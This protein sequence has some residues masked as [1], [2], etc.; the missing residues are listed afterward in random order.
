MITARKIRV[1]TALLV[2]MLAA[3]DAA[4]AACTHSTTIHNDSSIVLRFAELRSSYSPPFFDSQ[5]TGSRVIQPGASAT[6]SWTSDLN[7]TDASGVNNHWDV[8]FIRNIGRV[9]YCA[10]LRPGQDV[11]VD[12]PDL[13]TPD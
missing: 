4:V 7:C 8:Q 11:R 9:H 5:W 13:C 6:I 12:T 10:R 2:T 1:T 3:A